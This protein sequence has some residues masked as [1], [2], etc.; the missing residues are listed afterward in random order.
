AAIIA[1]SSPALPASRW[2][3]GPALVAYVAS[4]LMILHLLTASRYGYFGD[5]MYHMACGE[6][7]SWGYVDQP[8]LIALVAWLVRH[9]LGTSLLAIRFVPALAGAATVL[10]T[11][12][13]ARELGG[14]R[15]A[16][17]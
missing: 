16:Q 4:A 3:S 10:L 8:P 14:G 12:A 11:G 6:H 5:E 13:I 17:V 1:E 2:S 15:F 9:T 7:L